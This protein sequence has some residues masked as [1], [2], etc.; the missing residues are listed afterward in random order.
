MGCARTAYAL[1][2]FQEVK[3]KKRIFLALLIVLSLF[4]TVSCNKDK[5]TDEKDSSQSENS[6]DDEAGSDGKDGKT[7]IFKI[8]GGN[9]FVSYDNG[10]SWADLG[11]V[12]GEDGQNGTNGN[13]GTNGA[14]IEK[15]EF[16]K[17]GRLVV[18]L[19]DGTVLPP[20]ELPE[21][22]EHVHSF[23]AWINYAGNESVSC[24]SRL[25]YHICTECNAIEWKS[26]SYEDHKFETVTT[27]PTCVS[28]GFDTKTCTICGAVEI[29][30]EKETADHT[31]K[32]EY[33]H[34]ASFHWYDC[35]YCDA[36][37]GYAEHSVDES[38]YCTI[39]NQDKFFSYRLSKTPNR[40]NIILKL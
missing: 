25:F 37:E 4:L 26:G 7:P 11:T 40:H 3:M 6:K 36:T 8:E 38:G 29:V 18:T 13:N 2:V 21:K 16:D 33:S 15:I 24:E 34:N 23:G 28:K 22:D 32:T 27:P 31:W 5:D 10:R 30:N 9:L 1:F 35:E 39:C 17:E 19:T 20:V 14:T 12:K